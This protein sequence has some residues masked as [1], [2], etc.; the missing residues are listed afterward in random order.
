VW[1]VKLAVYGED[2]FRSGGSDSGS[3]GHV[4]SAVMLVFAAWAA[5][6]LVTGVRTVHG[7]TWPRALAACAIAVVGPIVLGVALSAF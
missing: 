6:L 2:V 7:W 5:A 4:F 1:P 3:G